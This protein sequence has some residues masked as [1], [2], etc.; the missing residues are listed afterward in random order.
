MAVS[1][2]VLS[3]G[4]TLIDLSEDTVTNAS[5]IMSG[6]VGHLADGSK[7]TGTGQGGG[8][9]QSIYT[10]TSVPSASLGNNG[11]IFIQADAG[12]SLEAYPED[13]TSSR[14]NNTSN[15]SACIG[16][17]ADEGS[18]TSNMYSSGQ[19]TTGVVEYTFD[20][21]GIPSSASITSV[22]CRVKAHEE[23]A[24]RSAFSLQLYAGDIP[25]GSK[26]TVS[27]TGN[28]IYTLST[29]SWTREELDS[30][31]LHTEYGYYGGL[32]AGA[33]LTIAYMMDSA[34]YNVTLTG[35]SSEWSIKGEG[36]Y[37]KSS[38]SWSLVSSVVLGNLIE[39]K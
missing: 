5:H 27:G 16:K 4:R 17:S 2:V 25:K 22:S 30:L 13:F 12:G 9:A 6:Y 15:A 38:G 23:N 19:S 8:S 36:I 31:V 10:G 29:G 3:D 14:M 35:D 39:R 28:T 7:V 18:S 26:T 21:S 32:V 33:T 1:K 37:Q 11:D 24:S 34:S 20:L